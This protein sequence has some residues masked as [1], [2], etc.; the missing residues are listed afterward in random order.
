M[1]SYSA[2]FKYYDRLMVDFP[3]Q[4]YLEY[5]LENSSNSK[6]GLDLFCGSGRMT[7]ML[8]QKGKSMQGV[9]I[10]KDMLNVALLTARKMGENIIFR[11]ENVENFSVNTQYDLITAV[12]DGINYIKPK[13]LPKVFKNIKNSLADNGTFIFDITSQY[14]LLNKLSNNVFFEDY[15]DMS[16]FWRNKIAKNKSKIYM[17]VSFFVKQGDY[18][19]RQD[20]EH[21]KY[22]YT[23]KYLTDELKKAG[24]SVLKITDGSTFSKTHAKSLR[25]IFVVKHKEKG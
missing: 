14:M 17:N 12:C 2:L 25:Q 10:S 8:S 18:Y 7:I 4:R 3:Y 6:R 24:L 19:T 1:D 20:E 9:D 5:I 11:E 16:Y 21:T 13:S 22:I 23:A 15:D